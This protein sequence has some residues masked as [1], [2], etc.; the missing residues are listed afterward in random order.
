MKAEREKLMPRLKADDVSLEELRASS[1]TMSR[2]QNTIKAV[3]VAMICR[4]L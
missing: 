2:W 1:Q 3:H 4:A